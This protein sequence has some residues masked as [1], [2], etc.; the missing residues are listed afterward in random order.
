MD[1]HRFCPLQGMASV[2]LPQ[3][4]NE[5]RAATDEILVELR[6]AK[7]SDDFHGREMGPSRLDIDDGCDE[8]FVRD[9]LRQIARMGAI[10]RNQ[11]ASL[12][13]LGLGCRCEG[14]RSI[15]GARIASVLARGRWRFCYGGYI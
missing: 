12:A 11:L 7:W 2:K 13:A 15:G 10:E 3:T 4:K 5:I 1:W 8:S 9:W 14:V 6:S